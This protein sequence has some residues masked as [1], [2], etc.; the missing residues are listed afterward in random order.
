MWIIIKTPTGKAITLAVESYTT[1]Y[2]VKEAVQDKEGIPTHQQCL[3]WA[4]G[5]LNERTF[6]SYH[7]QSGTNILLKTFDDS[8]SVTPIGHSFPVPDMGRD[9]NLDALKA[10]FDNI[11][12]FHN[13]SEKNR[14]A[15]QAGEGFLYIGM[16]G[17]DGTVFEGAVILLIASMK[18]IRP[19]IRVVT[20]LHHPYVV[21]PVGK[22]LE[23]TLAARPRGDRPPPPWGSIF[24][25]F[26]RGSSPDGAPSLVRELQNFYALLESEEHWA[27]K[28]GRVRNS[29][30]TRFDSQTGFS[31]SPPFRPT[32]L[33][34]F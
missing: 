10:Q 4:G 12:H 33:L 27:V 22:F 18:S 31:P 15:V 1:L 24:K 30:P 20:P 23:A 34:H 16:K 13:E 29:L 14:F 8:T 2:E 3:I 7:I 26:V 21:T 11:S 9:G 17:P 6:A 28:L 5:E 32:H 25:H 19:A